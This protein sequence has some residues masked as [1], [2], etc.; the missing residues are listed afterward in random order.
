MIVSNIIDLL[1]GDKLKDKCRTISGIKIKNLYPKEKE[2]ILPNKKIKIFEEFIIL[3]EK[4]LQLFELIFDIKFED[5]EINS[6]VINQKDIIVVNNSKQNTMLIGNIN[7]EN[8]K[9]N[10][11]MIL[12]YEDKESPMNTINE[13]N[14]DGFETYIKNNLIFNDDDLFS[15]IYSGNEIIGN[16]YKYNSSINNYSQYTNCNNVLNNQV[17]KTGLSLY[18][19]Y[20]EIY[21]KL[22]EKVNISYEKYYLINPQF[23]QEIKLECFYKNI[24]DELDTSKME[25]IIDNS[26]NSKEILTKFLSEDL[27]KD[28]LKKKSIKTEFGNSEPDIIPL[29]FINNNQQQDLMIYNNF[30]II[31]KDIVKLILGN[32]K[33]NESNLVKCLFI[34]YKIIINLPKYLNGKYFISVIGIL[35]YN[36]NS[37][38]SEYYLIYDNKNNRNKHLKSIA[39]QLNTYLNNLKFINDNSSIILNNIKIGTIVKYNG[40]NNNNSNNI[41]KNIQNNNNQNLIM[42]HNE[43]NDNNQSQNIINDESIYSENP[44]I[45]Y[46]YTSCPKIGLENIGATCYMNA[47]LQCFCH[48][49]P[50]INFFKYRYNQHMKAIPK[51]EGDN[52]SSSF[53][54]LVDNLWPNNYNSSSP[55]NKKKYAPT[56]FKDKISK[57]N[58]L[59]EGVA[60]NDAKDLVNFI[61]MTLHSELNIVNPENNILNNDFIIDQRNQFLVYKNFIR[62]TFSKNNSIISDLFYAINCN[63]TLCSKCRIPIYNCQIYFFII[64]PLEEVRK[65]KMQLM[66]NQFNYNNFYGNFNIN[67]VSLDDCFEY[68]RKQNAMCGE[69]SMYCNYC[70]GNFDCFMCTNLITGPNILILLL[71][72]GKGIEF[73]VK[74]NFQEKINLDKYIQDKSSGCFYKLIGVITHIGESGMGGHFIAYCADPLTNYWNKY[75]DAIVTEVKDFQKEAINFAMPYLLFYQKLIK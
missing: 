49:D 75:N 32:I 14:R 24:K 5:W 74:I 67:E 60:A 48:I 58:P 25:K 4:L 30:D 44:Y 42:N 23:L 33:E 31:H 26:L 34:N 12:D 6:Y 45:H 27:I 62:D 47:T 35:D 54:K 53:K 69:N 43:N 46:Y 55:N 7:N 11:E 66:A 10:I 52:L 50:L 3:N 9:Y 73:N 61:I 17:L 15:P 2:I 36:D 13:I 68:D 63:I 16:C 19:N 41:N 70:K 72:R 1:D 51:K 56:D 29:N 18:I 40:Q 8:L 20:K 57:M 59:F 64:F 39:S 28:I 65:Y 21:K 37:F 71:N 22:E 38:I